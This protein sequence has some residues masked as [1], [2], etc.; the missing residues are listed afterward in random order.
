[1]KVIIFTKKE[2]WFKNDAF[3]RE[4]KEMFTEIINSHVKEES[5]KLSVF[6]QGGVYLATKK[7]GKIIRKKQ[8]YGQIM[9]QGRNGIGRLMWH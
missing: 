2:E 3:T 6:Q 9:R 7:I 8:K 1:M 4:V 5:E